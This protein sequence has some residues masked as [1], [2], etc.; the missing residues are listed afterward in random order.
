LSGYRVPDIKSWRYQVLAPE[1]QIL[2]PT[3]HMPNIRFQ[4]SSPKTRVPGRLNIEFPILSPETRVPDIKSQFPYDKYRDPDIKSQS[5]SARDAV[6]IPYAEYQIP[7]P[8]RVPDIKSW[9]PSSRHQVPI[10]ICQISS[11]QY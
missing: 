7:N 8:Y 11:S 2:S 5:P 10:P 4:I 6:W 1:F 3:S 9:N